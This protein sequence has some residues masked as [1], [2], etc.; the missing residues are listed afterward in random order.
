LGKVNLGYR[1][2]QNSLQKSNTPPQV[3]YNLEG[4]IAGKR[5]QNKTK[6]GIKRSLHL[7]LL[8]EVTP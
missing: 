5:T 1:N 6:A 7:A 2:E 3:E 8:M 4:A